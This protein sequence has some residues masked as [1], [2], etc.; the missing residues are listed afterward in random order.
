M[1]KEEVLYIPTDESIEDYYKR[2]YDPNNYS[3]ERW[4]FLRWPGNSNL[5]M[6]FVKIAHL[7]WGLYI[8]NRHPYVIH[9]RGNFYV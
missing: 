2:M 7:A 3:Y 1:S 4:D 6:F 9:M 8:Q 5:H